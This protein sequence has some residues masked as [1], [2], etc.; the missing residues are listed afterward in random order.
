MIRQTKTT[1]LVL[2]IDNLLTDLLIR[3]TF[4]HQILEK[5]QFTKLSTHQTFP[6]YSTS[7]SSYD[8][9]KLCRVVLVSWCETM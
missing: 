2:T 8:V 7:Y 9:Y 6:L 5:S 1:K 4:F 3:Q